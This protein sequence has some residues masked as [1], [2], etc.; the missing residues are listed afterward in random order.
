MHKLMSNVCLF[1]KNG[2]TCGKSN[3]NLI[4]R[5]GFHWKKNSLLKWSKR[6]KS[7][8]FYIFYPA[9]MSP[10]LVSFFFF[11]L[12]ISPT[13][14]PLPSG[15][16]HWSQLSQTETAQ[17]ERWWE[18]WWGARWSAWKGRWGRRSLQRSGRVSPPWRSPAT[19]DKHTIR[20]WHC[21]NCTSI[22][23][24]R[25]FKSSISL[26]LVLAPKLV[27]Y[28]VYPVG[29]TIVLYWDLDPIGKT[30]LFPC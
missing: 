6:V 24:G 27:C 16:Q 18:R 4:H 29:G 2:C 14:L 11:F 12:R 30:V 23:Q 9:S 28:L 8:L 10:N 26:Y 21:S 25:R 17:W 22:Y 19:E 7:K 5:T 15:S 3:R 13:W 1:F 20:L